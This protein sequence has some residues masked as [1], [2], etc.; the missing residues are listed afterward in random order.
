M[1]VLVWRQEDGGL[2]RGFLVVLCTAV[3][4]L[5]L[6]LLRTMV[7]Q[8]LRLLLTMA[9]ESEPVEV[10]YADEGTCK[11]CTFAKKKF[12]HRIPSRLTE[13]R[14]SSDSEASVIAGCR[15][16]HMHHVGKL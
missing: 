11:Q 7:S 4:L 2:C 1:Y 3:S 16:F 13:G 5:S 6:S 12:L 8:F 10:N 9:L 14:P 15:R